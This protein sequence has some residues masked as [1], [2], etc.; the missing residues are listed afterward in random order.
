MGD[1]WH[2]IGQ[3]LLPTAT[4]WL[5]GRAAYGLPNGS[6]CDLVVLVKHKGWA[7]LNN[8][9]C[10]FWHDFGTNAPTEWWIQ[11]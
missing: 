10:R 4:R 5:C 11:L 7:I 1:Y 8:V 3:A 2:K 9:A 6:L